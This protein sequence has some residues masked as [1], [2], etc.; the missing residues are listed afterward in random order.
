M[1]GTL[2]LWPG[3]SLASQ[4]I[5]RVVKARLVGTDARAESGLCT[6]LG[7]EGPGRRCRLRMVVSIGPLDHRICAYFKQRCNG[8]ACEKASDLALVR[9][10]FLARRG[11]ARILRTT[12]WT[13]AS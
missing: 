13:R 6:L 1:G 2:T 7:P 10:L 8:L 12:Q 5:S 4:Y 11:T 9:D 3:K